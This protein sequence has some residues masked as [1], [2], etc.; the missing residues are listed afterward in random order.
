MRRNLDIK[1]ALT[2][3]LFFVGLVI[4]N[5]IAYGITDF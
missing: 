2:S 4:Y 3:V 1:L 5:I